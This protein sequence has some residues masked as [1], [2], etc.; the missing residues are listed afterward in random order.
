MSIKD[1]LPRLLAWLKSIKL[2]DSINAFMDKL[3]FGG[4]RPDTAD[5]DASGILCEGH[6]KGWVAD[7]PSRRV[8]VIC[9]H[10][11]AREGT[12]VA[13]YADG[14]HHRTRRLVSVN[15][16]VIPVFDGLPPA[17]SDPNQLFA[18]DTIVAVVD[19]PF[20]D[21]VARYMVSKGVRTGDYV[22]AFYKMATRRACA[23]VRLREGQAA[24]GLRTAETDAFYGD[25]GL[26][27]FDASGRVVSHFTL[28]GAGSGPYYSHPR[29]R[30]LLLK[31][32]ADAEAST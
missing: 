25:S 26:P 22:I 1:I 9:A 30:P 3:R 31:A 21:D 4:T 23:R 29:M 24:V 5:I 19:K 8:V 16:L 20:E 7:T 10:S 15:R 27:W 17:P 12:L 13:C 6:A 2:N 11:N 14:V 32:I 18:G 28:G